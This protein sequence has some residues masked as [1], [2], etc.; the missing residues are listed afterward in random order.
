MPANILN[1]FALPTSPAGH[2][3]IVRFL[4]QRGAGL[5]L[6]VPLLARLAGINLADITHEAGCSRQL[7]H[8]ALRGERTPPAALR[9]AM[10]T[11]L[12]IDPWEV[13]DAMNGTEKEAS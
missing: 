9:A 1:Q 4:A 5:A 3:E 2:A 7:L 11:Q 8:F 12:G 13:L 10:R 6:S